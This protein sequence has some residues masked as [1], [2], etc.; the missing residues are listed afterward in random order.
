M[1]GV[2]RLSVSDNLASL[3][4]SG[5][6]DSSADARAFKGLFSTMLW[7]N[8]WPTLAWQQRLAISFLRVVQIDTPFSPNQSAWH[9]G[10]TTTG[11]CIRE[12][13]QKS[14]LTYTGKMID[15][16]SGEGPPAGLHF[17]TPPSAPENGP[18]LFYIHGGGYQFPMIPAI[19]IPLVF[20]WAEACK[21]RQIVFLEYGLAPRYR[22]PM[23]LAQ[24][25]AGLQHLVE[26]EG[27]PASELIVGG[28]SAG[29]AL[30]ASL[31][32]HLIT[33]CPHAI[34]VSLRGDRFKGVFLTSPWVVISTDQPSYDQ[35]SKTDWESRK[36]IQQH[37][38][39]WE[40]KVDEVWAAPYEA[41]NAAQVWYAAF[42]THGESTV[43]TKVLVTVGT[44]EVLHDGIV[45]FASEFIKAKSIIAGPKTDFGIVG[46]ESRVLVRSLDE[47][48][49]QP[50]ADLAMSYFKGTSTRA[51]L[52]WLKSL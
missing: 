13:S 6:T 40:P 9:R 31:L 48:H 21:A 35:N 14:R 33:P 28:D 47:T 17:V 43:A 19:Q 15:T 37:A 20:T 2:C 46:E 3:S 23:Q 5:D 4:K 22:Y 39:L 44:S 49:V 10:T 34:P 45:S 52:A 18:T 12:H 25:A 50:G 1:H 7:D 30:V 38:A 8:P 11:Q 41:G 27:L 51:T 26:V 32:A 16:S 36:L 42:P 29:G 24:V